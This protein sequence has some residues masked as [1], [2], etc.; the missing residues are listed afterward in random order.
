MRREVRR[1]TLRA[2]NISDLLVVVAVILRLR[3]L[4]A[5]WLLRLLGRQ[6]A[7][8]DEVERA[9]EAVADPEAAARAIASRSGTA[10]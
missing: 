8:L 10:Q 7:D 1:A 9:D 3:G 2:P 5:A 4:L 6:Q